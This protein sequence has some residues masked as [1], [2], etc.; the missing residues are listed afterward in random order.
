MEFK[1]RSQL[2]SWQFR[3][4]INRNI[5]EFKAISHPYTQLVILTELI[6]T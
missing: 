4:R 5:M 2:A 6:E 1:V 3:I